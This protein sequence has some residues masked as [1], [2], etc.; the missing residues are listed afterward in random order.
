ML[1]LNRYSMDSARDSLR[2][3]S[4]WEENFDHGR[5]FFPYKNGYN[6]WTMI[7]IIIFIRWIYRVS[8]EKQNELWDRR[9]IINV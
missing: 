9:K 3:T 1:F 6:L 5:S 8:V 4:Q 7:I 2:Y